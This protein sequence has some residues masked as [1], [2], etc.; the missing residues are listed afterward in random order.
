MRTGGK[1]ALIV[2]GACLAAS[3]TFFL[4]FAHAESQL[5]VVIS[6]EPVTIKADNTSIRSVLE[7]LSRQTNLI[8][9]SEENLDE[10]VTVEIDQRTLP[11]AIHRILRHKSF[12]LHQVSHV[13]SSE[14]PGT[15]PHS[16][17]W[18]FSG[19]SDSTLHAWTI[20]PA[21]RPDPVDNSE[22]IDYQILALS[23]DASNRAE[24]MFGFGQMGSENGIAYL[25]Q[26][27]SD[28]DERVRE[29]AIESLAD[30]G[31]IESVQALSIALN[32]PHASLRIDAVDALGEIRG[33]EA[34]KLLQEAMADENDTVRE[35]AAEWLT[36]LAWMHD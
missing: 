29:A 19:E 10:L 32:D 6:D 33:R 30:L 8:V 12:M 22:L 25:Q 4:C 24:A 26:G 21:L 3:L 23:D 17:L 11:E 28:P 1:T 31:G 15:M 35:A 7:E 34:I 16:R 18:I 9:M 2:R 20:Q 14:F 5:R 27:L 13:S 36:E